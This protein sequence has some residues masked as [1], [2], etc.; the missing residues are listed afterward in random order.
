MQ[1]SLLIRRLPKLEYHATWEAMKRF[2]ETRT[3][4]TPDEIWF[5]EHPPVFTQGLAGKPE[6]LLDPGNIPVVQSDRGGQ[7]TYH[8]PGQ[9]MMYVLLDLKRLDFG[10]RRLVAT[11]EQTV[12]D[13][14][15]DLKISA[16]TKEN[17]PGVYVDQKKICSIGLR[18]RKGFSYHGIALNVNM[19][20]SP[21]SRI[22]PCGYKNLAMTQ[23][24]D[25][26]SEESVDTLR[27]K[28]IPHFLQ[29]FGYTFI[30]NT[31]DFYAD[32]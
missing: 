25:F 3:A 5:L 20:L 15:S 12:I 14:L 32:S 17:A 10:P 30:V 26:H 1:R 31:K 11:L 23:V 6:H 18:I 27:E 21:F 2:T 13:V 9:L 29:N 8:G 19:D 22:N 16:K 7:I 24:C 28:I 4:E